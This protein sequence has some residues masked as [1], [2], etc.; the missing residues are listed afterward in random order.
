MGIISFNRVNYMVK[1]KTNNKHTGVK[2]ITKKQ[3]TKTL[4]KSR[5]QTK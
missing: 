1:N 3:N 5:I 4:K 2:F